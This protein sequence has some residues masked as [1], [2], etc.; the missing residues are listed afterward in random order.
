V[1][2]ETKEQSAVKA[3]DAH[4]FSRQV[5]KSSNTRLPARKLMATVFWDRKKSADGGIHATR[6]HN[7]VKSVL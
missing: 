2:V 3:V 4:T 6:D 1:N 7:N 5:E